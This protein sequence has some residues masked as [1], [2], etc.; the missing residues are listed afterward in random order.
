MMKYIEVPELDLGDEIMKE[1]NEE[2]PKAIARAL[3]RCH[4]G[5]R[6]VNWKLLHE[7]VKERYDTDD[8]RAEKYIKKAR[9]LSSYQL[10]GVGGEKNGTN[11]I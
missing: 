9:E 2:I 5:N 7:Y 10:T 1:P 3:N 6:I 8:E 11:K 4:T